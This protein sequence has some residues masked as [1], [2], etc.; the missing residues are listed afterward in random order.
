[1]VDMQFSHFYGV[2]GLKSGATLTRTRRSPPASSRRSAPAP[3]G[4]SST[5]RSHC[6]L[7]VFLPIGYLQFSGERTRARRIPC[8]RSGN[9]ARCQEASGVVEEGVVRVG[10]QGWSWTG[11]R[12]VAPALRFDGTSASTTPSLLSCCLAGTGGFSF[13]DNLRKSDGLMSHGCEF[14]VSL[15]ICCVS[16]SYQNT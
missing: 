7:R 13:M 3:V 15:A 4:T 12:G 6:P 16:C 10:R 1:M 14:S 9:S 2:G 8:G 11:R 5:V